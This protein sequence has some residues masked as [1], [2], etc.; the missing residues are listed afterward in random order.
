MENEMRLDLINRRKLLAE[1]DK[2]VNPMPD[3]NGLHFLGGLSTAITEIENAPTVDAVEVVHGRWEHLG[4]DEW[5][6]SACGEVTTT[7]GS[8]EKPSKKY[9]YECGA[10]MVGGDEDV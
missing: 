2:F 6:C 5:C 8:W 3:T 4:G 9:C 1:L 7:E 10:K